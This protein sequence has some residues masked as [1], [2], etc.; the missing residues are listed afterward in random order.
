MHLGLFSGCSRLL[1]RLGDESGVQ[2][3][4]VTPCSPYPR[5]GTRM[6]DL[7]TLK[8]VKHLLPHLPP[9]LLKATIGILKATL[10]LWT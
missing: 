7:G 2:G 6:E 5:K 10:F 8:A 9:S 1:V 4:S 3:T